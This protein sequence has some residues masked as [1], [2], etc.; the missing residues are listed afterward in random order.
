MTPFILRFAQRI[1]PFNPEI[2]RYDHERQVAQVSVGGNWLGRLTV[3]GQAEP[4]VAR[5]HEDAERVR[6]AQGEFR[7]GHPAVQHQHFAPVIP[8]GS[9]VPIPFPNA[10][11]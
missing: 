4:V 5:L 2:L 1:P 9:V 7:C 6:E 11:V 10:Q 3:G 8:G